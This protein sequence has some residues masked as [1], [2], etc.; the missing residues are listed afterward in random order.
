MIGTGQIKIRYWLERRFGVFNSWDYSNYTGVVASASLCKELQLPS[1]FQL[2]IDIYEFCLNK[3]GQIEVIFLLLF[4]LYVEYYRPN[5]KICL[6][7]NKPCFFSHR[8]LFSV[9]EYITLKIVN[10]RCQWLILEMFFTTPR[11]ITFL[12]P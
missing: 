3:K 9:L 4:V 6:N 8:E 10:L 2:C 7:T 12:S 1:S 11:G 5:Y